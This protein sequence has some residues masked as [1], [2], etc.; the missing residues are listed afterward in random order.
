M[1][2][3]IYIANQRRDR[4]TV[5]ARIAAVCGIV[6]LIGLLALCSGCMSAATQARRDG[7]NSQWRGFS[8][9]K[10]APAE[11][12]VD[13]TVRVIVTEDLPP[14]VAATYSHPQGVIRIIGKKIGN[15]TVLCESVIGHEFLHALQ[16]QTEGF[17]NP[18]TLSEMGY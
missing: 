10:G 13:I 16:Y 8:L 1:A 17:A 15:G 7:F 2:K 9:I 18:D 5:C 6:A 3:V 14:G 12:T 4:R 11:H